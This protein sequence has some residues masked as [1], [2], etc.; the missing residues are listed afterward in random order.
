MGSLGIPTASAGRARGVVSLAEVVE[1]STEVVRPTPWRAGYWLGAP[2]RAVSRA[3]TAALV[4]AALALM[5]TDL[6]DGGAMDRV[7]DRLGDEAVLTLAAFDAVAGEPVVG[8]YSRFGWRHPGPILGHQLALGLRLS[9]GQIGF[10]P[11]WVA[12]WSVG[13]LALAVG[14]MA[15]ERSPWRRAGWLLAL[16]LS[17]ASLRVAAGGT[18]LTMIWNPLVAIAPFALLYALAWRR[19]T[20][21]W[22]A[23][24]IVL[25]HAYLVQSHVGYLAIASLVA[26]VAL[27]KVARGARSQPRRRVAIAAGA[28]LGVAA[29]AWWTTFADPSNLA[30]IGEFFMEGGHEVPAPAAA[31]LLAARRTQG[32]LLAPFGGGTD[33]LALGLLAAQALILLAHTGQRIGRR[34]GVPLSVCLLSLGGLAI[35][36]GSAFGVDRE[37]NL[38]QSHWLEIVGPMAWLGAL[39]PLTTR[40]FRPVGWPLVAGLAIFVVVGSIRTGVA[41]REAVL[42]EVTPYAGRPERLTDLLEPYF[43]EGPVQLRIRE[44]DHDVWGMAAA[45]AVRSAE[46][47][48]AIALEPR[49][50]FMFGAHR[51]RCAGCRSIWLSRD[52]PEGW[53]VLAETDGFS[54]M[55]PSD[56]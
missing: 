23:P 4:V 6:L 2:R 18:I 16:L 49:F 32:P 40:R 27:T 28:S 46:R 14:L 44:A 20:G 48:R 15:R 21:P 33:D 53:R 42:A 51:T 31:L 34:S 47:G 17:L 52:P 13:W 50:D 1:A 26:G 39:W 30:A 55:E 3:G 36:I 5:A 45:V 41:R 54:L 25:L 29:A 43:A 38:H 19:R 24:L 56:P 9:G 35:A 8:P 7:A 10:L 22:A 12:A 37:I 11:W